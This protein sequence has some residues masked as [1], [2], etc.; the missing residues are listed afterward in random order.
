M[1]TREVNE[2]SAR[3]RF[4]ELRRHRKMCPPG[5]SG[6]SCDCA[7]RRRSSIDGGELLACSAP[8]VPLPPPPHFP[9]SPPDAPLESPH[10]KH[11]WA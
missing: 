3:A 10:K 9:A 8:L 5:G 4:V 11:Y 1:C 7:G 6:A 2:L